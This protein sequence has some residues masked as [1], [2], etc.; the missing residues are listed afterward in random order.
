ME[1]SVKPYYLL[2]NREQQCPKYILCLGILSINCLTIFTMM[3][4]YL[5][6]ICIRGNF[7]LAV[8]QHMNIFCSTPTKYYIWQYFL[9]FIHGFCRWFLV[10]YKT[11]W[12][13]AMCWNIEFRAM[14][15]LFLLVAFFF[16]CL[17][18]VFLFVSHLVPSF[19]KPCEELGQ[20]LDLVKN[21]SSKE[22]SLSVLC[23]VPVA[24]CNNY[25]ICEA[26]CQVRLLKRS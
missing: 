23:L 14:L 11:V 3:T 15:G 2:C 16:I 12:M 25:F 22:G 9:S 19:V 18:L 24:Q 5:I 13:F 1:Q 7:T 8:Q 20:R 17:W 6:N 4:K 26:T 21:N 10:R